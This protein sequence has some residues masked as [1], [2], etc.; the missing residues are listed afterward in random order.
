MP[1]QDVVAEAMNSWLETTDRK[2]RTPAIS[3]IIWEA[4]RVGVL[5]N[6]GCC[7]CCTLVF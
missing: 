7:L 3:P 4:G 1:N 6:G 5:R 2:K